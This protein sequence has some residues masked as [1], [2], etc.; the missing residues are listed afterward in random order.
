[1]G[2]R[3]DVSNF[4]ID[5]LRR[6]EPT[7]LPI[8]GECED[9]GTTPEEAKLFRQYEIDDTSCTRQG[10]WYRVVCINRVPSN[11]EK[12]PFSKS[13]LGPSGHLERMNV[14]SHL[15][16]AAIYAAYLLIR[17]L[18]TPMGADDST[19]S[20]LAAVS[21]GSFAF[22]FLSS[23]VYHVYSP[24]RR[25]SALTR[26]LDYFGIYVGIACGT[27]S[28]LSTTTI[29]LKDVP[30]QSVAD[31]F[32]GALLLMAFFTVRRA[33][34]P[35][36][37]TRL[38]ILQQKCTLGF[39]RKSNVDLEHGSL[40]AA[41]GTA[42]AFGWILMIPGAFETLELD[43][44]WVFSGSRFVGTGVLIAGMAWDNL[45]AFPDNWF[46][47]DSASG[48][49]CLCYNNRDGCG[50]GWVVTS[51]TIWHW[52]ALL[53]TVVT[54]IGTEYVVAVSGVLG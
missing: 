27:L 23:V 51:H 4:K 28:D 19:T 13:L 3:V 49:G 16:A 53:S 29:N 10:I 6:T 8:C 35:I 14:W 38:P 22:T 32:A 48:S 52:I 12:T 42:L 36:D 37:E 30:I 25:L 41:A 50:G 43:C 44:A 18:F 21:Y 24:N 11:G 45:V 26:L 20:T 1:M 46:D 7:P 34:L 5:L 17:Q 39:G 47:H 9:Q 40:R 54:S 15:A 33:V 2:D 31:V